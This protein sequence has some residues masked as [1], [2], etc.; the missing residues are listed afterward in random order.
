M[1]YAS[2]DLR[3]EHEGIIFGLE[4]L[5]KM[6]EQITKNG[7][8][9]LSDL[10]KMINFLILF[11]DKCHHGK[12]E[13]LFFPAIIETGQSNYNPI[14]EQMLFEHTEGRK[15][16]AEMQ[17]A[18]DGVFKDP[19][20]VKAADEYIELL[21]SHIMKENNILFNIADDIIAEDK[22]LELLESFEEFEAEVMGKGTHEN[23]HKMLDAFGEKYL[24]K[25]E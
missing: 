17:A 18:V 20:F 4:I 9:E 16:L 6:V 1:N 8:Y 15:H 12:E 11:A 3:N 22:Q 5:E 23:L 10:S 25:S 13:G 21:R 24:M 2:K 7:I 14:I 19:D